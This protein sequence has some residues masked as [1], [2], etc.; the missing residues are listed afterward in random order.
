[1]TICMLLASPT[2]KIMEKK[3][4]V[5][6]DY[7]NTCTAGEVWGQLHGLVHKQ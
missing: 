4:N 3:N 7:I 1:M 5:K 6:V 2:Y